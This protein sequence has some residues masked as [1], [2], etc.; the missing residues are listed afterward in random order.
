MDGINKPKCQISDSEKKRKRIRLVLEKLNEVDKHLES[1]V[2]KNI[3][4]I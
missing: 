4:S 3:G 1:S 2:R